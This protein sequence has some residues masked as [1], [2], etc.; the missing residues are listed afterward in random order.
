M[1]A[2]RLLDSV[3]MFYYEKSIESRKLF[4]NCYY[5]LSRHKFPIHYRAVNYLPTKYS[6]FSLY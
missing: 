2:E 5:E 1:Y 4:F 3:A 6:S